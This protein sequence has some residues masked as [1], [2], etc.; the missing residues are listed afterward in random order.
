[1]VFPQGVFTPEALYVLKCN[2]FTAAVNTEV[3]PF[4]P[5]APL[6]PVVLACLPLCT[7]NGSA[8]VPRSS[9]S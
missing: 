6:V 5:A 8:K 9:F 3:N 1:M 4:G 2:N 7:G